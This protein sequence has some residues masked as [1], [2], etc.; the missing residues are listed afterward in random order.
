MKTTVD[1]LALAANLGRQSGISAAGAAQARTTLAERPGSMRLVGSHA[2][3][4]VGCP[5]ACTA[6]FGERDAAV[7]TGLEEK[8]R[9]GLNIA[10]VHPACHRGCPIGGVG[11]E[12]SR[13][14]TVFA[15]PVQKVANTCGG[16]HPTLRLPI[17][18]LPAPAPR[19]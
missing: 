15:Q 2:T 9:H 4:K 8:P 7:P 6:T 3:L 10:L 11:L 14:G 12:I 18:G 16:P 13:K 19:R 1:P 5:V 17:S